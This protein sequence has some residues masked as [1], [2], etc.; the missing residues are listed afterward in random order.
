MSIQIIGI[1]G[2][3][4]MGQGIAATALLAG[5]QV[6][7]YDVHPQKLEAA[8]QQITVFLE[9]SLQKG[10]LSPEAAQAAQRNL[11]ITTILAE[12]AGEIII[13]AVPENIELKQDIFKALEAAND[14]STI[15]ATNTSSL[16]VTKIGSCLTHPERFL[17]IHFFNPAPLMK[18]V[19]V[20]RGLTTSAKTVQAAQDFVLSLGKQAVFSQDIPGFIVNRVARCY[21]L[22]SL[23]V[24]EE[25]IA[26]VQAIDQ[27]FVGS[28]FRMGPFQLM[29]LIGIDTN[30]EVTKSIYQGFFGEPRFR[31]SRTQ[32]QMVDAGKLGQKTGSGFYEYTS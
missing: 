11:T 18:L 25:G 27:L 23:R 31:P 4:I 28:G 3:G 15:L 5:Y 6:I 16:S 22:E 7:L 1:A 21:Y 24:L 26:S 12:V 20:V 30:H 19:E 17:G 32:Q 14:T 8:R 13:E 2:A 9:K 29:D 10:K